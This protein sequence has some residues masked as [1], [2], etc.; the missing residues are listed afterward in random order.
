MSTKIY[1][2]YRLVNPSQLWTFVDDIKRQAQEN[3][4]KALWQHLE[5]ELWKLNVDL[6]NCEAYQRNLQRHGSEY[7]ARLEI[8]A[9]ALRSAY[10]TQLSSDHRNEENLDVSLEIYEA[11]GVVCMIPCVDPITPVANV[12]DFLKED[13][14]LVEFGY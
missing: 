9:G 1:T 12:L 10:L 5:K 13:R 7:L 3:V 6:D 14:R 8:A 11:G 4:R 2:A